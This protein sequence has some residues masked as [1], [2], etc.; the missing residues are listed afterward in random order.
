MQAAIGDSSR[1]PPFSASCQPCHEFAA[2]V[3]E[4][5]KNVDL[6]FEPGDKITGWRFSPSFAEYA[7]GDFKKDS[8]ST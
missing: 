4:I 2:V 7:V 3:E 5:G 6:P 1:R 8:K